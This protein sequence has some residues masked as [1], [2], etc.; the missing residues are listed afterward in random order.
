MINIFNVET[1]NYYLK[2]LLKPKTTPQGTHVVY[3]NT[4]Y[5][6]DIYIM[7]DYNGKSSHVNINKRNNNFITTMLCTNRSKNL[8][9]DPEPKNTS[10]LWKGVSTKASC[11]S[12]DM[13][14]ILK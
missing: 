8:P 5:E 4:N 14:D 3:R 7:V 2:K 6:G 9:G 10:F 13:R 1:P 12:Q 11:Y